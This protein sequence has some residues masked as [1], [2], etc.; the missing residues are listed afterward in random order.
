MAHAGS[1]VDTKLDR[2]MAQYKTWFKCLRPRAL[3]IP[4]SI[5]TKFVVI[6]SCFVGV[7]RGGMK[8]KGVRLAM[9]REKATTEIHF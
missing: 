9:A 3:Q 8:E 5:Y 1:K 7:I 4:L 6:V 2:D